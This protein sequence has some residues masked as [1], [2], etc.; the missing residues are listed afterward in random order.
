MPQPLPED[1]V[2]AAIAQLDRVRRR[3][4]RRRGVTAVD[5]GYRIA[6]DELT[7][8][9]AIRAHV[10]RKLPPTEVSD[11][12]LFT[13]PGEP[14][15]L[16]EFPVDVL[17]VAYAPCHDPSCAPLDPGELNPRHRSSPL[18]G[19]LSVGSPGVTAGTLGAVVWD[20]ADGSAHIL[21][22]WHVLALGASDSRSGG[23]THPGHGADPQPYYQA[24][25]HPYYQAVSHPYYQSVPGGMAIYQPGPA[26]G[27]TPADIVAWLSRSRL[28][29]AMDAALARLD[30]PR[31]YL[32]DLLGLHPIGGEAEPRLGMKVVK[33]GRSTGVTKGLIDGV[34]LSTTITYGH[35]PQAFT[36]QL[37]IVPRPPWPHPDHEY[38]V[39]DAGDSG[40]VWIDEATGMAVGLNFAGERDPHP[41]S[42]H[43]LANPMPRVATELDFSFT[44]LASRMV[45]T[46]AAPPP[47]HP[48]AL[49]IPPWSPGTAAELERLRAAIDLLLGTPH[50]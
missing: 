15:T 47:G 22:N 50:K 6:G 23:C 37:H 16:G 35:G 49:P 36:D 7:D 17:E 29:R 38:E 10:E 32:R 20:R 40:A 3:W 27:G 34:S 13:S 2:Q 31:P 28:D 9:L 26:D 46:P 41:R 45:E 11:E 12:D 5:V 21:S 8:E 48:R 19:G 1:R 30:G 39:S 14:R 42:E 43:A 33:S 4:L 18:M 24:A 25:P 44:P